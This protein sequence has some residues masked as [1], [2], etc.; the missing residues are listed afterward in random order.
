MQDISL[1]INSFDRIMDESDVRTLFEML[2]VLFNSDI[3]DIEFKESKVYPISYQ[4]NNNVISVDLDLLVDYYTDK[5][6]V[7]HIDCV[8]LINHYILFALVHEFVHEEQLSYELDKD[9]KQIYD[10]CFKFIKSDEV[11]RLTAI[12]RNVIYNKLHDYLA[13][14]INANIRSYKFLFNVTVDGKVY[15][16]FYKEYERMISK[17]YHDKD[18]ESMYRDEL[19]LDTSSLDFA[20]SVEEK[21]NLGVYLSDDEKLNLRKVNLDKVLNCKSYNK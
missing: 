3:K 6:I 1:F 17:I 10:I 16:Y 7:N 19:L 12:V 8:S 2:K 9:V 15:D 11:N 5:I 20:C 14:E 4:F 18:L 21:I 13:I